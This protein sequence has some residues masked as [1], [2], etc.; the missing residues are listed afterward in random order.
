[1]QLL[2]DAELLLL[3]DNTNF[4]SVYENQRYNVVVIGF[5]TGLRPESLEYLT[6][7]M[8]KFGVQE[9]GREFFRLHV[10]NMKNLPATMD[11]MDAA[12]FKQIVLAH[13][14]AR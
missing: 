10:G 4:K 1:M 2:D 12:I 7:N 14:D 8:I 11:H 6:V 13:A 3:H 5:R 9:D